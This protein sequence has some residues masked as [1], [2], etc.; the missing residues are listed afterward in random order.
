MALSGGLRY[1][2]TTSVS[3]SVKR[4]SFESLNRLVRWGCNPWASQMR[5][6]IEWLTP[7]ALAIVRRLQWVAPAGFVWRGASTIAWTRS[8]GIET[9]RPRPRL[10]RSE[11]RRGGEEG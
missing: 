4:M 5:W 2:P 11:E 9:R 3:F 7:W 6:T 8:A 1:S 10:I